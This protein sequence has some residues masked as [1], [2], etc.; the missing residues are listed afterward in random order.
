MEI[1]LLKIFLTIAEENSLTIA[2]QK[3]YTVQ[4]NVSARLKILEEEIGKPLFFRT[5][6]G[7]FL[8]ET[9][10]KL[11]PLAIDI[12]QKSENI[13]SILNKDNIKGNIKIG[14]T[15]S[16]LRTYLHKPLEKW[17]KE[18]PYAKIKIKTG[19]SNRIIEDLNNRD[20]DIGVIIAR[21][22]PKNFHILKEYKSELCLVTPKK[23]SSINANDLSLLQPMLLGDSCFFG[24]TLIQL[25]YN[26]NVETKGFE[27]LHSIESILHC[28]RLGLGF[29]ILPK[30]LV[31]NH[32]L[33]NEISVHKLQSKSNFSYFK[34]CLNSRK[35][36]IL[37]KEMVKYL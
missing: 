29:S 9:G 34:V 27:Y 13:K 14:L 10:E 26:L 2:S 37:F 8:T 32:Y 21:Q 20:I 31:E 22:K 36:D 4:S 23:I 11:K 15:E 7:M 28:I 16:F 24:Q 1:S 3:L 6:K 17:I 18:Y 5:K 19:F 25:C 33:K 35:D 30:C 12:I